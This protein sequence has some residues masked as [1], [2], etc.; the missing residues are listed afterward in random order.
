MV[1]WDSVRNHADGLEGGKGTN[2]TAGAVALHM[3]M[4]VADRNGDNA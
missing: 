3:S 2:A 4:R 1:V